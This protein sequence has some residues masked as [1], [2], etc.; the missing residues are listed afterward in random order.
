MLVKEEKVRELLESDVAVVRHGQ[1]K[2]LNRDKWNKCMQISVQA[3]EY[4]PLKFHVI[5]F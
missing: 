3:N 1:D 2:G 5:L 4:T